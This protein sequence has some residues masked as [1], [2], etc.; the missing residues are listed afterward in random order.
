MLQVLKISL[1]VNTHK[2]ISLITGELKTNTLVSSKLTLC[3]SSLTLASRHN[4][5]VSGQTL[6]TLFK[7]V[8]VFLSFFKQE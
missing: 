7:I 1:T 5:L 8:V 4:I 3:V 6:V 2:K